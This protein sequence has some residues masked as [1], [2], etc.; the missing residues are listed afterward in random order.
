M[1][2]P[3][4]SRPFRIDAIGEGARAVA[5]EADETERTALARRFALLGLE[6]LTARATLARAGEAVLADGTLTA[7]ATQAC[8][9]TGEPVP[10]AIEAPF[11]L[12]FVPDSDEGEAEEIELAESDLDVI[13]YVGGSIDLGEA[14]AQTL[15]LAL[16]PFPR[17]ADADA[18]LREAGVLAEGE[19]GPFAALRALKD[20]LG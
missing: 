11:A 18:T 2:A 3:E 10:A 6:R 14:V 12:R 8:V 20:R 5:I 4:F 17:C 9:A 13:G 19:A 15:A 7:A 16:D 1:S